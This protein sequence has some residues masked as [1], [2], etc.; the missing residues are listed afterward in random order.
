MLCA[1][2]LLLLLSPHGIQER[3]PQAREDRRRLPP[4]V[5]HHPD[6]WSLLCSAYWAFEKSGRDLLRLAREEKMALDTPGKTT[7]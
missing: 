4:R 3:A 1:S 5:V 2:V 6:V 7:C